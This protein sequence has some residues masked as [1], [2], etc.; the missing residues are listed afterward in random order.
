MGGL[1]VEEILRIVEGH[2]CVDRREEESLQ[3]FRSTVPTLSDPC[4]E[5]ADVTHAS[6]DKRLDRR[7]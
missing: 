2:V 6:R 3:M 5:H 7:V 4:N 1:S